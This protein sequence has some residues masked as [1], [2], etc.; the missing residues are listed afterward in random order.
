M[1]CLLE[2]RTY[3]FFS[4]YHCFRCGKLKANMNHFMK[5]IWK[6]HIQ[7]DLDRLNPWINILYYRFHSNLMNVN[8]NWLNLKNF[9]LAGVDQP[10]DLSG[11]KSMINVDEWSVTDALPEY[12]PFCWLLH[13]AGIRWINSNPLS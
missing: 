1:L 3:S 7:G 11:D 2:K 10:V 6:F 4:W 8:W 13:Y 5:I 12:N 9:P